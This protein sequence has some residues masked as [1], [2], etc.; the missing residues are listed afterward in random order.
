MLFTCCPDC[1]TNFRIT[2]S[3][4]RQAD[5]RVRCGRCDAVFYA[6]DRLDERQA[7]A[8][9]QPELPQ[10]TQPVPVEPAGDYGS[11][12]ASF[13]VLEDTD[14]DTFS[15]DDVPA[16]EVSPPPVAAAVD[17]K[18]TAKQVNAALSYDLD[19]ESQLASRQRGSQE[20]GRSGTKPY[21]W[22]AGSIVLVVILTLQATHHFRAEL[23]NQPGIGPLVRSGYTA[24]GSEIAT[25]WNLGQ[26][27]I[28]DWIAT[29][30]P[31][32]TGEATLTITARI[33][34]NG[35]AAQPYPNIRLEL[36]DRWEQ[37]VGSRVFA[38][39]KYLPSDHGGEDL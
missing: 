31:S 11:S 4:L 8:E 26:Y 32:T 21:R 38:P 23:V 9:T 16:A 39:T 12:A 25:E 27:E 5:G 22:L 1:Q 29:A 14:L 20:T 37:T 33:R 15:E 35:P 24:L 2:A 30:E 10:A 17:E 36:K 19:L 28:L 6:N 3:V 34:N 13:V 18:L 7:E